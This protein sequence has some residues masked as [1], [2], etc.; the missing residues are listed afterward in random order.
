MKYEIMQMLKQGEGGVIANTA[1]VEGLIANPGLSAYVASKHGVV[2]L[3]KAV[4]LEYAAS[5]IRVNAICPGATDTPLVQRTTSKEAQEQFIAV[6]AI[7]R[8][9]RPEEMANAVVWLC[10]DEASFVTGVALPVDGGW[11][12]H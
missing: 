6:Q 11:T 8:F 2:G 1:S 10:S 7:K 3:T 5:G 9:A 4:A 12:A